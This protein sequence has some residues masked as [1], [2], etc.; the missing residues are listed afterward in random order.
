MRSRAPVI[1]ER[2]AQRRAEVREQ[3]RR[4]RLR[5]TVFVVLLALVIAG[6][7][8]LERSA[9]VALEEVEVDGTER[10]TADQVRA[11][12]G[13]EL[14]TSTLRLRLRPAEERVTDLPLVRSAEARRVDPLTVRIEVVERTPAVLAEGA[15]ERSLLDRDG[16]VIVAGEAVADEPLEGLP[17]V[18]L[19]DAPPAVGGVAGDDPALA[20][21]FEVWRGLSGALRAEVLR[22]DAQGPDELTLQLRSQVEVRFGRADRLD[23]KVRALGAV[24]DDVGSTPVEAI[25]VRAPSA[26]VVIGP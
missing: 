18:R 3:R 24:L 26:P 2:I 8:L 10:L 14:G 21:A 7:V 6:F 9:L 11:A 4:V 25:D 12:A 5:R 23:E 1:D 22:Y 13:L 15:G 19:P 20:N 17:V 16:I